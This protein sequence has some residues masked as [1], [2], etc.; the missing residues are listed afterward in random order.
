MRTPSLVGVSAALVPF[1][2][3]SYPP[4]HPQSLRS[5]PFAGFGGSITA[6]W[7]KQAT[8]AK[9]DIQIDLAQ[10]SRDGLF[11]WRAASCLCKDGCRARHPPF[12][13]SAACAQHVCDHV[14][15]VHGRHR[16]NLRPLPAPCR[17]LVLDECPGKLSHCG[18]CFGLL[19]ILVCC[20]PSGRRIEH[21]HRTYGDAN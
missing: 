16:R 18:L 11:F 21:L 7:T 17:V 12:L 3:F 9:P 6:D 4:S 8:P 19:F 15:N 1:C 10:A 13:P 2:C 20:T 14:P 5:A